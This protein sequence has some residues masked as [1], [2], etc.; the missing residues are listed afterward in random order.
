M[1]QSKIKITKNEI[2]LNGVPLSSEVK[3]YSE[4][5]TKTGELP[6]VVITCLP[7]VIEIES[8]G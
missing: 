4:V 3:M 2:Y 1:R 8:K 6:I 7:D 5:K